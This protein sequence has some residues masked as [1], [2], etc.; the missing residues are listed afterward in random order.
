MRKPNPCQVFVCMANRW[1]AFNL[2]YHVQAWQIETKPNA[3]D[4]KL[5]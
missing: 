5:C 3:G 4:E 2:A 1:L